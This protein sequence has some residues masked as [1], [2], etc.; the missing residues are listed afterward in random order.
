MEIVRKIIIYLF[1]LYFKPKN[2]YNEIVL[3]GSQMPSLEN[4]KK[5]LLIF[6]DGKDGLD[7]I[8]II[9]GLFVFS[10]KIS[11]KFLYGEDFKYA[12]EPYLYGPYSRQIYSDIASLEDAGYVKST[13]KPDVSWKYF[14]LTD[15]GK[16]LIDQCVS[17]VGKVAADYLKI[18]RKWITEQSFENLLKIIYREYP[19]YAKNSI[20]KY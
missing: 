18:L 19:E 5:T 16:E 15:K 6:L 14:S 20:F 12:F 11:K 1:Y 7:P 2:L 17:D 9:K 8:R 3:E 13:H 4:R 10:Q